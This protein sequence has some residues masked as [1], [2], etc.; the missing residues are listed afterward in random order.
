MN[1]M[2]YLQIFPELCKPQTSYKAKRGDW[3][4]PCEIRETT[5]ISRSHKQNWSLAMIIASVTHCS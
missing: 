5:A 3:G 1:Y 4:V 2:K